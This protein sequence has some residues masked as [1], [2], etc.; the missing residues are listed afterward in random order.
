MSVSQGCLRSDV[1]GPLPV[2]KEFEFPRVALTGLFITRVNLNWV[3][4]ELA[5]VV[6]VVSHLSSRQALR[7]SL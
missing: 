4:I 2:S 3:L 7:V 1:D 6:D 5:V